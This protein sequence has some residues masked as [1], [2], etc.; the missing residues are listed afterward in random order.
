[1]YIDELSTTGVVINMAGGGMSASN[2]TKVIESMAE[3]A[4]IGSNDER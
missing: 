4:R 1:M 2:L 3:R